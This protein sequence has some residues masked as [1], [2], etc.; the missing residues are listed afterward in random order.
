MSIIPGSFARIITLMFLRQFL[1]DPVNRIYLFSFFKHF[2]FFS[3]VLVPFFTEWG[4]LTLTQV[5]ILQS[6]FSIWVFL[7]EVPTGALADRLGRRHSIAIGSVV[8]A[9]AVLVYGSIPNFYVFLL[10]EF[11]FAVGYAFVSGADQVLLYDTLKSQGREKESKTALGRADALYLSGMTIATVIGGFIA[12]NFGLNAPQLATAIPMLIAA[13]IG[14][15]IPEPK[16]HSESESGRYRDIVKKGFLTIR[17]NPAIRTLAYDSVLVAVAAYFVIWF[18]QPVMSSLNYPIAVFGIAHSVLLLS[19]IA[20]SSNFAFFERFLGTGKAY[21]RSSAILTS[22]SLAAVAIYPNIV[23]LTLLIMIGGG[24]GYSRATYITALAQKHIDSSARATTLSSIG[25]LRRLAL[26]P[27]NP[28]MGA[29]ATRS[30]S[31]ALI[32]IA[33][34]PLL[35]LFVK[36][37][38]E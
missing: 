18:Y 37:E 12:A 16:I 38:I 34:F 23:T 9:I 29:L 15:S 36:E 32:V 22:L 30:L 13:L 21:L 31:L 3:A 19:Q 24:I 27:L 35:S 5:Q 11:I 17:D 7:L 4:G 26:V 14:W 28:I 8:V 10:A 20:V 1:S 6:W 2:A 33:I 25:M